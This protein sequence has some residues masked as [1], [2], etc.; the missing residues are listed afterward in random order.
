L[1]GIFAFSDAF[2]LRRAI[3]HQ[4]GYRKVTISADR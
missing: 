2:H 3:A 4:S 1:S